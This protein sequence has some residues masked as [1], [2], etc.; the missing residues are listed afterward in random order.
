[1]A[2]IFIVNKIGYETET[3]KL[4]A[5]TVVTFLCQFFNTAFVMLLVNA[6]LTEQPFPTFGFNSGTNGDF[7]AAFFRT[8]GNTLIS[9]MVLNA[10]YPII[11]F[12]MYWGMRVGFRILDRPCCSCDKNKTKKTSIQ[13]YINLYSGPS[14]LMHYKYSTI[15]NTCFVTFMY[16]FGLPFLFP[17]A[18]LTFAVLYLSEKTMLYY[19]YRAPPMYD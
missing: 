8:I 2:V 5:V 7:N 18:V 13:T 11:D 6:D 1:M 14:Y 12:L 19:C 4:K 9:T 3:G 16:G 15:L 10:V 17:V